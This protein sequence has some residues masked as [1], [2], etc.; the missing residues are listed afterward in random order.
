MA[1]GAALACRLARAPLSLAAVELLV[2]GSGE[3]GEGNSSPLVAVRILESIDAADSAERIVSERAGAAPVQRLE[4][5]L[6]ESAVH[7]DTRR[8]VQLTIAAGDKTRPLMDM[9]LAKKRASDRK[10]WL[11]K[12]GDLAEI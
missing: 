5:Q 9:L 3:S 7:P 12:K 11:E 4:V 10:A 2:P 6:R 1:E 8:L